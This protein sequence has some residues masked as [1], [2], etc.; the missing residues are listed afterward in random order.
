MIGSSAG[1][2]QGEFV[3]GLFIKIPFHA[4]IRAADP[5][6]AEELSDT[7]DG[8]VSAFAASRQATEESFLL[9]FDESS[10]PCRLRAAEAARCLS[11]KL[12]GLASRLHGWALL[13]DSGA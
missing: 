8:I 12:A 3:I 1:G 6:V 4:Q 2:L 7:V 10:R 13:L 9:T 5:R 11:S